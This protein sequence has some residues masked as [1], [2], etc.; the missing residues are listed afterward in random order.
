MNETTGTE[1]PAGTSR[2]DGT[3][4]GS[5]RTLSCPG[6]CPDPAAAFPTRAARRAAYDAWD[7]EY[8]AWEAAGKPGGPDAWPRPPA[9]LTSACMTPRM[10][11]SA[12]YDRW[13][14]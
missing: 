11:Y 13:Q 4:Q 2:R 12:R 1:C 5:I 7:A 6:S 10:L 14:R 8:L 3:G 9:G